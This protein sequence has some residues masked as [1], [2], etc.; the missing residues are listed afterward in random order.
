MRPTR[1]YTVRNALAR[2]RAARTA[3][4]SAKVASHYRPRVRR[5]LEQCEALLN[6]I[7]RKQLAAKRMLVQERRRVS[8]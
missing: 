4:A 7:E 6:A 1:R 3:N 5:L 8:P 2:A